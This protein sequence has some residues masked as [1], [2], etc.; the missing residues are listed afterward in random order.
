MDFKN[1]KAPE[2]TITIDRQE[3]IA[4]VGSIYGAIDI[5][6]K[7]AD[8]INAELKAELTQKL[9]EFAT[10]N[11]SLEEVFENREQIEVSKYYERLPK[12]TAIATQ[13]LL[14]DEIYFLVPDEK[15]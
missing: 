8:Q 2:T 14:D 5:L 10:G 3:L 15:G 7:R 13:Q 6:G 11:E 9:E 12:P 1:V 4:K